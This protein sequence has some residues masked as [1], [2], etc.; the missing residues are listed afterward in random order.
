MIQQK[1]VIHNCNLFAFNI[2]YAI[3]D[4][5]HLHTVC[6]WVTDQTKYTYTPMKYIRKIISSLIGRCLRCN[7]PV[8]NHS[9]A[10]GECD[11]SCGG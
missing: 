6:A 2:L 11:G 10:G 7:K 4:A 5:T 1:T 8:G 9:C 3:L